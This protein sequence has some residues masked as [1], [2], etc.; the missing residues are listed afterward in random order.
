MI[1]RRRCCFETAKKEQIHFWHNYHILIDSVKNNSRCFFRTTGMIR[2]MRNILTFEDGLNESYR[3]KAKGSS[4]S[5][6]HGDVTKQVLVKQCKTCWKSGNSGTCA[7]LQKWDGRTVLAPTSPY[8]LPK[9]LLELHTAGLIRSECVPMSCRCC[10]TDSCYP[11]RL[12]RPKVSGL[13]RS[14]DLKT[15]MS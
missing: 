2:E 9:N 8:L 10:F 6:H 12:T 3:W 5:T 11:K 13:R 7:R 14:L 15:T 1:R 4:T